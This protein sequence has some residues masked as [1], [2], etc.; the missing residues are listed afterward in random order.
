[1]KRMIPITN[2]RLFVL[3]LD[4]FMWGFALTQVV[5]ALV[6]VPFFQEDI[7]RAY[8]SFPWI[9]ALFRF[10][11]IT[12]IPAGVL[13]LLRNMFNLDYLKYP[14]SFWLSVYFSYALY[15]IVLVKLVFRDGNEGYEFFYCAIG[16]LFHSLAMIAVWYA[17]GK[18]IIQPVPESDEA[19]IEILEQGQ[20]EQEK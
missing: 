16:A 2:N 5:F 11:V 3:W 13:L 20:L 19:A 9:S 14:K 12:F 18:R 4:S 8:G 1:M 6:L 7:E 15:G 17:E 10:G